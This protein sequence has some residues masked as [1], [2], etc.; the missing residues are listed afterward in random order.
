MEFKTDPHPVNSLGS[1][2]V[3]HDA[4]LTQLPRSWTWWPR[5]RLVFSGENL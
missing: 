5:Q 3:I 4:L 1:I 2:V